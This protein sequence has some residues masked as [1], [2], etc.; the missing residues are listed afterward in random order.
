MTKVLLILSTVLTLIA[1]R[2]Q[3]EDNTLKEVTPPSEYISEQPAK[4]NKNAN[5]EISTKIDYKNYF[6]PAGSTAAFIGD[7]NEFASYTEKTKWLSKDYVATIVDNGGA[8]TMK[9]YRVLDEQ[10]DLIMDE[11]VDG[12]P[13]DAVYPELATLEVLP[14]LETYLA[15][16]FEIGTTFEHWT[17]VETEV[18]LVTPY[19]TF[20]NVFVIEETGEGFTNKKYIAEGY[21]VI[22]TESVMSVELNEEYTV[23]STLEDINLP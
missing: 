15:G 20:K 17:I 2:N 9:V 3:E 19:K 14:A 8:V 16:P 21:G 6:K 22:K 10:I 23:T 12:M 4:E 11:L 1:C 18:T 7:G 5:I 13:E